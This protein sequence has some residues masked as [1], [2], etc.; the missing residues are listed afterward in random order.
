MSRKRLMADHGKSGEHQ[1]LSG[2]VRS[3][4]LCAAILL[5][6]RLPAYPQQKTEDLTNKSL[7]DLMN[8]E[9]TSVS[10]KEQKISQVAAAIFVITQEDIVQS[11]AT[12]IPDLLR[13][14]PGL[15]VAQINA[16]NWAIS[17]RGLTG[18]L[19]NKLL[20]MI[21]GRTVY[22]P[23]FGGV[24][25]DVLDLP[26]EDIERIEVIR[27]PGGSIWGANAVNG[28]INIMTKKAAETRGAMVVAGG[29]NLDQGFGTVQYGGSLGKSTDYRVYAK[30]FNQDHMPDPVG[31]NGADGWH[32]LR[33]GFRADSNLSSKDTLTV[34]GGLYNGREGLP[35]MLLPSIT[36]PGP[37]ATTTQ[38]NLS[39]GYLQSVW[40]HVY[41]SR[42][43]TTLQL[44]YDRYG[45]SDAIGETRG[46]FD[47]DFQHH[48][49][50]H[51]RQDVVWGLDY[52]YSASRSAGSFTASLNP[53]S[54]NTQLFSA[55]IEDEIAVVPERLYLTV[56]TKL[57]HNY[58]TG[59]SAMPSGRVAWA[60]N[61]HQMFWAAVSHAV[62]TPA[63][64]DVSL[65][66]SLGA[67]PGPGGVPVLIRLFGN[68]HFKNEGLVASEIGYRTT[69]REQLSVDFAAYYNSYGDLQTV[70][71]SAPFFEAA[72]P[73]PH[74]V[75]PLRFG[76]LM[77]GETHGLEIAANWK[78]TNRWT[79]SPGYAFE[80][81]HMH[82]APT[83]QDAMGS[84]SSAE[85]SSPAHSAQLR[86]H[87]ALPHGLSWD[88]AAYFVDR[89]AGL[90]VPSYTRIDT[91]LSWQF[92]EKI[93]LSVA[94]QNLLRDHHEEF[95]DVTQTARTTLVKRSA[96]A[97]FT[98]QF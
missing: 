66:A 78:A 69:V 39:G 31:Q 48:F 61:K 36:S 71:A 15:D 62:R 73:P 27:G 74:L 56:G 77:H 7:E 64:T 38:V 8:I 41:S 55:F 84:V 87:V 40:N 79:L 24:F 16:S 18:R 80:R 22:V 59:F 42:S 96:Y 47:A 88:T 93:G 60:P 23:T 13:M 51:E 75:L 50:W 21:D 30:Y 65:R 19:A 85:G 98:W 9:V 76:N 5:S 1:A 90:S 6:W 58:Y 28:V 97:K 92:R 29:G 17:A 52:R 68:P 86:S 53:A 12:S 70:E 83:S 95:V 67:F 11:G 49:A 10:R 72:P 63:T 81:I 35:T 91:G 26:L 46:S 14:V 4:V 54:L 25:W 89:L 57:E 94:G 82:L 2:W 33:G 20:V 43:D 32:V 34:Y 3:A 37:Q 44:S 45:R